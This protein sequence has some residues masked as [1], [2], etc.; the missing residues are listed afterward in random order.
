MS[1]D[2]EIRE[3]FEQEIEE[4][5]KTVLNKRG[6]LPFLDGMGVDNLSIQEL[7]WGIIDDDDQELFQRILDGD[8][9]GG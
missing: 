6:I 3:V 8:E 4:K 7:Y 1:T 2:E 5:S 9:D